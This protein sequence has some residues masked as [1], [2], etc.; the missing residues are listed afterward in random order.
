MEKARKSG[1][2]GNG[3]KLLSCL[4]RVVRIGA[5][6]QPEPPMDSP[7]FLNERIPVV[8]IDDEEELVESLR[9]AFQLKGYTVDAAYTA[10]EGVALVQSTQPEI[11]LVDANLQEMTGEE[12][13]AQIREDGFTGTIVGISG[14]P[15]EEAM[16]AAGGDA[17]RG[18]PLELSEFLELM[19]SL[20]VR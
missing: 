2:I 7:S 8:I 6:S 1:G 19:E 16:L 9:M 14:E 3:A 4:A 20:L 10:K 13:I 15:R 5:V 11:V 17:F 18:K 12:V